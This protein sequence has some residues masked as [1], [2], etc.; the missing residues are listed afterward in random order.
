MSRGDI[1]ENINHRS[2]CV[3]LNLK[4]E[5]HKRVNE[6]LNKIGETGRKK[7]DAFIR[8]IIFCLDHRDSENLT[9]RVSELEKRVRTLEKANVPKETA[10]RSGTKK[11]AKSPA[12]SPVP[13]SEGTGLTPEDEA[14]IGEL[15]REY[16]L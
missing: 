6:F 5:E 4:N 16:M 10:E 1:S 3:R 2:Y 12:V 8:A 15:A 14:I 9:D 7:N 13:E 11:A